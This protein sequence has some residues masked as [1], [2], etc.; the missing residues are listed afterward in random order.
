MRVYEFAK[1]SGVSSKDVIAKL[2]KRGIV[3]A[4]HMALLS[5]EQVE[6]LQKGSASS[7]KPKKAPQGGDKNKKPAASNN[8]KKEDVKK[9]A[10]GK[11]KG[12]FK[13]GMAHA[14]VN[15]RPSRFN[16][17][18]ETVVTDSTVG[19][20]TVSEA[21]TVGAV[22][23]LL[24]KPAHDVIFRLIKN[25]IIKNVNNLLT[26]D[27]IKVIGDKFGVLVD[28]VLQEK[29]SV[30][31]S[32]RGE[33]EGKD[34][35]LPVVV[36]MGHV[37]HGKTTLLDYLRK[38]N[39][40][41]KEKGGITQHLGA[42]EVALDKKQKLIFLDTPGHEAFS[43]MR[44][45]GAQ[46]TDLVVIII[47][48]NDG[49]KPQ[50]VEA[51]K[52]A[53]SAGAPIVVA[54]NK[55]DKISSET[56]LDT[57][58][59]QLSQYNLTPEDWGGD[60]VCVPVSAKTGKGV[61]E[62]LEMLLLQG[63]MLDLKT[64]RKKEARAFVLETRQ[65]K[66]HG[67]VA[68]VICKEGTL[69]KG[70]YF[71][72]GKNVGKV[73]LLIDSAGKQVKEAGPSVP[74]QVVGFDGVDALGDW[75]E[76]VSFADFSKARSAKGSLTVNTITT[77]SS[78]GVVDEDKP[79][80]RLMFKTDMVGSSQAIVDS[81]EKLMK[82]KKNDIVNIEILGSDVGPIN[83][84]DVQKALDT[85]SHLFG[86]H[87]KAD[88]KAQMFAKE[89]GVKITQHTII[90]H[91]LEEVEELISQQ[92]KKV[93]LL[94][95]SGSA[96]VLKVFPIKGNKAI[97]GC[98]IKTGV[99]KVGDKVVCFRKRKEIGSG[100]VTSLQRDKKIVPEVHE[101][102][103]CGFLT[104]SFHGWEPGDRIEIYAHKSGDE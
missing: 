91:L 4:N 1:K 98:L 97:A 92:R 52:L 12:V 57:V 41:D 42:Y 58:K 8:T 69:R 44:S 100:L 72:C 18:R 84:G 10:S 19:M 21:M 87:V 11:E 13:K 55:I 104:D 94:E 45:R 88:R 89:K 73:R 33:V 80:L 14:V 30:D 61:S 36:V 70:D 28:V 5:P 76:V 49:I 96:E 26:I 71:V 83:E 38:A 85:D 47:A 56:Q 16:Q 9:S 37:D 40:A 64:T 25:G 93:V 79:T 66:G 62:L 63:E 102:N 15:N 24:K 53:Q 59:T 60:T 34:D 48:V 78:F 29:N 27:E 17:S 23:Q 101:G 2:A 75:L 67:W 86:L 22:A 51:I 90:Y 43:Y 74:V 77:S 65:V 95:S 35:R 103:D 3:V 99:I 20:I 39:V 50:T 68:T 46:I 54:L 82:N 6:F 7:V 32:E 31:Q 81:L